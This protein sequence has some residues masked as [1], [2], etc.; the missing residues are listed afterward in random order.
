MKNHALTQSETSV[1]LENIQCLK[2]KVK[3]TK[4]IYK[5]L[6]CP[7]PFGSNLD[8]SCPVSNIALHK[9]AH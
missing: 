2:K 3:K 5:M 9:Y 7:D 4:F 6:K 8:F 1:A